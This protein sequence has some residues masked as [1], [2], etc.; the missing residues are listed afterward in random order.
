[1]NDELRTKI[2]KALEKDAR[3][4]V[5]NLAI[6]FGV[7]EKDIEKELKKMEK[8]GV[9]VGY[10]TLI[11]WEKVS[12]SKVTAFIFLKVSPQKDDG[13]AKIAKKICKYNNVYDVTLISGNYDLVVAVKASTL[14][15]VADFVHTKLAPIDGVYETNTNF[16][17]EKYKE[18]GKDY[19]KNDFKERMVVT[20]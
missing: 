10:H 17:L 7:D 11:D 5:T 15:E 14:Q 6:Q 18:H 12:S 13:F 16:I 19:I 20:P 3:I 9:I 4:T 8:D 2:L 1:M